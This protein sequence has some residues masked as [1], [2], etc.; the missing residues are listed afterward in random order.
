MGWWEIPGGAGV[1][2]ALGIGWRPFELD[3]EFFLCL[4]T[5]HLERSVIY[6]WTG[7]RFDQFQ[8][9]AGGGGRAFA[10]FRQAQQAWLAFANLQRGVE[11]YRE[12]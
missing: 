7:G 5:D 3:G 12:R 1:G 4:L 9:I 11:L 8:V 6:R 2:G 10:F